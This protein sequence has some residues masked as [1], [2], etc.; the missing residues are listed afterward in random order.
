MLL[1]ASK[2]RELLR[3]ERERAKGLEMKLQQ[4]K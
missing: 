3:F 2:D 1:D 4:A